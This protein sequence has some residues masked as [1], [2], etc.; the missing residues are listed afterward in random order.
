MFHYNILQKAESRG[1]R[2][3][4]ESRS[5]GAGT[6]SPALWLNVSKRYNFCKIIHH[7]ATQNC[8][9]AHFTSKIADEE[10][11]CNFAN[12]LNFKELSRMFSENEQFFSVFV[13]LAQRL[14]LNKV[15]GE[16]LPK[17]NT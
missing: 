15:C 11:L 9:F 8:Q 10:A 16:G 1:L 5:V 6:Q 13:R 3:R 17:N 2:P 7:F 12:P 4:I 14:L